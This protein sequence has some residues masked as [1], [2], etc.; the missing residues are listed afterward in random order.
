MAVI[1]ETGTISHKSDVQSGVSQT[2][3]NPWYR[4]TIVV[5][6]PGYNGSYRKIALQ[7]TGNLVG[8]LEEMHIGDR[9]T[10]SYQVTAREYQGKFYNNVELYKVEFLNDDEVT[11]QP[12]Q[13]VRP[14]KSAPLI[15]QGADLE[16]KEDL[17]F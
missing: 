13:I 9:V 12:K 3:G 7:A 1:K 2:T 11:P 10:V 14:A 4:Q 5:D 6:I 8:D 17:P 15:P 16:S